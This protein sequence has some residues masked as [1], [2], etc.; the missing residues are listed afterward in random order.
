[1]KKKKHHNTIIK[2]N[3]IS[4]WESY[5]NTCY[6]SSAFLKQLGY[7]SKHVKT[8]LNYF[9]KSIIHPEDRKIFRD[10]FFGLT[11]HNSAFKQK[12]FLKN[13][14]GKY[15]EFDCEGNNESTLSS[16]SNSKI[17]VFTKIKLKTAKVFRNSH[18]FYRETAEMTST[19]SWFVDFVK[20][21]S[22]W[23]S[24]T[25]KILE[26]PDDY[27]PSL[28]YGH[29]YY[30]DDCVDK[31]TSLFIKCA[32]QGKPFDAEMVMLTA[33]KKRIW[34]RAMGKPVY[35]KEQEIVGIRGVF[36]NI[37]DLKQKQVELETTS[38]IITSQNSK[39][40]NFAHIVSHNLR[41]HTSNLQLITQLIETSESIDEKLEL[42]DNVKVVSDSL[43]QTIDHLNEIVTVQTGINQTKEELKFDDV[44]NLTKD[45]IKQSIQISEAKIISDFK[46]AES[47]YYIAAYLQSI[48]L[49][50]ITNAIKY[51]HTN[52]KP[53]IKLK[54]YLNEY[55]KIVLEVSDNGIGIDLDQF[56]NKI[57]GMYKTFHKNSDGV[58]IGLFLVKN[59]VEAL[60]GKISV[61]SVVDKGT[62]FKIIF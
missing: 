61:S 17:I 44:L 49:N 43:A 11:E 51:N 15:K 46:D 5:D 21:K 58:G 62:T 50:L 47:I 36:Q 26:Y 45:A 13:K 52:H 34:V 10:H 37:D 23:D 6:W 1:M 32:T 41:S 22:Y 14:A 33:S 20:Q 16:Q 31:A 35:N 12:L 9:L 40:Y 27:V 28:K 30:A 25:R 42:I 38:D 18:L 39:L 54:T 24:G 48:M 8:K 19:G 2:N 60:G 4:Y 59:Q 7:K 57:F 55:K 29:T 53:I 3:D 56:G